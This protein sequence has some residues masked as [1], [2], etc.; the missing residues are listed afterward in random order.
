MAQN[1]E[2]YKQCIGCRSYGKII[3]GPNCSLRRIPYLPEG[4]VCPCSICIVKGIC[5]DS[6]QEFKDFVYRLKKIE[7]NL[8]RGVDDEDTL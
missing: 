5:I 8:C 4:T 1:K 3:E 7:L 2:F 6:C